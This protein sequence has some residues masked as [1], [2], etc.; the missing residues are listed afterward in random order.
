MAIIDKIR[1]HR[2]LLSV[3]NSLAGFLYTEF[4]RN[5]VITVLKKTGKFDVFHLTG[6]KTI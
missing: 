3:N 6:I 1:S 2:A 5:G 4:L